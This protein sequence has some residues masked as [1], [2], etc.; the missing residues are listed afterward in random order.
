MKMIFILFKLFI[1]LINLFILQV[2]LFNFYQL[3]DFQY[4]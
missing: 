2:V 4:Y 1:Y 3:T